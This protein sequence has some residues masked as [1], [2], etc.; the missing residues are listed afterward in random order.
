L[1]ERLGGEAITIPGGPRRTIADD[2]LSYAH[3]NN[4]TQI[5]IG[6][7]TRTRWFEIL[8]GSVVHDLVRRS[9]NISVNVIAGDEPPSQP[10]PRKTV[11]AAEPALQIDFA[12]YGFAALAVAIALGVGK[13]IQPNL[14]I[15]NVDLVFLTAVVGVA[16]RYGLLPS[17]F[18][19]VL[20]SLAYN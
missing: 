4:V 16:V 15:A 9:G 1:A 3:E 13:L 6:K 7:S 20:A 18:A 2:V 12:A 14:G 17:L 11:R 10:I 8:H 19:S 5:V